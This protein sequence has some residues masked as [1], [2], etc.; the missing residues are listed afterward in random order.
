MVARRDGSD[1]SRGGDEGV[2]EGGVPELRVVGGEEIRAA[3]GWPEALRAAERA[4]RALA[5]GR[6]TLPPPVGLHLPE[7]E[8]EVHVKG[9]RIEGADVFAFKVASGFY[10]N[11]AR[12]LPVGSG[13]FLVFDAST[14]FPVA[15]LDDGGWLTEMR[16]GA[17]GALAARL[18]TADG[19][20]DVAILGAGTQAR[21]QLAALRSVR[22]VRSVR[23]WSRS[24][25]EAEA[26]AREARGREAGG[27]GVAG[28]A[29]D[30]SGA[31]DPGG[32]APAAS[33]EVAS[34]AEE[35]VRD[36]SLIF[37][38]TPARDPILREAWVAAG[39][40]VV[41]VGSDGEG[42]CELEP[43]LVERADK[44][45]VDRLEQSVRLGELQRPVASG[46]FSADEV[47]AEL[48]EVLIGKAAGREREGERIVCDLTGVGAQDAAIAEE[49]WRALR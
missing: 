32:D 14:G 9:A 13:L 43:A 17:A 21:F 1:R 34:T 45:V 10:R 35:A 16:T 42:K 2:G 12:G 5:E 31:G 48:G 37:T 26:F 29:E 47:H 41:A 39:A 6:V 36:A 19:P 20:L 46:G 23:V 4:F 3:V 40:T 8:G 25:D 7:V 15:L 22:T 38:V 18:L 49:A 33:I 44:V 27:R 11:P 28:S 30:A 24:R